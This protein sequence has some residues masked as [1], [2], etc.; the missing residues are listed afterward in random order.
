M[1]SAGGTFC[2]SSASRVAAKPE[3]SARSDRK[4]HSGI[5][6]P[7]LRKSGQTAT[8][9]DDLGRRHVLPFERVKGGCQTGVIRTLRSESALRDSAAATPKIRTNRYRER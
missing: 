3:L 4:A 6:L 8:G 7:Q 9:N 2:P 1:I 5:A